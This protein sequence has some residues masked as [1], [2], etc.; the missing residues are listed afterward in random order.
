MQY[1]EHLLKNGKKKR[2]SNQDDKEELTTLLPNPDNIVAIEITDNL[3]V[4]AFG[5]NLHA[6]KDEP[7]VH[8]TLR[9]L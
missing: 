1:K 6:E 3:P 2:N 8:D 5:V 9:K 4:S 7:L